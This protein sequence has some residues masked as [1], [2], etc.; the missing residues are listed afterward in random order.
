MYNKSVHAVSHHK[1]QWKIRLEKA[2][3]VTTDK[4][5]KNVTSYEEFI[6]KKIILIKFQGALLTVT[7]ILITTYN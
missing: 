7:L 3:V 2:E 5:N 1:N 6:M 4:L